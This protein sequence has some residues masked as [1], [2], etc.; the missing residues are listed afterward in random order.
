MYAQFVLPHPSLI[1]L[2]Q[3]KLAINTTLVV[4]DIQRGISKIQKEAG[5]QARSVSTNH[6]RFTDGGGC[7]RL[8]SPEPGQQLRRLLGNPLPYFHI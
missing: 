7:L 8:P 3:T 6:I 5:G 2:F 1:H 4:S